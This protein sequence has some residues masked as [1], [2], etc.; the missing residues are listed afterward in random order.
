MSDQSTFSLLVAALDLGWGSL[1][2]LRLI[3]D[4]VATMIQKGVDDAPADGVLN[5]DLS[6]LGFAG[7]S[8]VA[9]LIRETISASR[10][11]GY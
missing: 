2:K 4:K 3:L 7:A 11:A 8:Q 9:Q 6:R 1:G 10:K 5:H